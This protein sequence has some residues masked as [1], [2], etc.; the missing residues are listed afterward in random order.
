MADIASPSWP[1]RAAWAG[2]AVPGRFGAPG[3]PGV[4][5]DLTD[6]LTLATIMTSPEGVS[7]LASRLSSGF[8]LEL[9]GP[10]QAVFGAGATL[11]WAGDGQWQ[12][13]AEE[14]E[15]LATLAVPFEPG[16]AVVDQSGSRAVLRLSGPATLDV[17]AKGVMIDLH[18]SVFP[19]G[20]AALTIVAHVPVQIWRCAD[21]DGGPAFMLAAPR[22][23]ATT[24]W[25]WVTASAAPCGGLVRTGR[26]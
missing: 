6:G 21:T 9:P 3:A 22:S 8:G 2:I 16:I 23:L 5:I 18:P 7:R 15:A 4:T 1:V 10:R 19:I 26:G 25:G 20:A 17:L 12:L 14:P 11:L 24:V 13:V